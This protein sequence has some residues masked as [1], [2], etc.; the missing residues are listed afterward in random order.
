[1]DQWEVD[2]RAVGVGLSHRAFTWSPTMPTAV[3]PQPC[4][5]SAEST[6]E[7]GLLLGHYAEGRQAFLS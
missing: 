3:S 7:N 5:F 4:G 2:T 6:A 1:M